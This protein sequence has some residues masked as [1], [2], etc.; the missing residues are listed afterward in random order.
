MWQSLCGAVKHTSQRSQGENPVVLVVYYELKHSVDYNHS[1]TSHAFFFVFQLVGECCVVL[2]QC[3]RAIQPTGPRLS[4]FARKWTVHPW[5]RRFVAQ[6]HPPTPMSVNWRKPN[7]RHR[8]AS[9]CCAK[10]R[11]V[12][13]IN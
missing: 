6:I 11:A 1:N 9:R 4:A 10:D 7:A 2:V 5:W 12:S 3:V 13:T 8:D